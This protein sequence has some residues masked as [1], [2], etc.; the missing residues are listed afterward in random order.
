MARVPELKQF[1]KK[2]GIKIGTIVDLIEYRLSREILVEELVHVELP[3]GYRGFRAR[4]FRS[5]MDGLEHLVLQKGEPTSADPLM[6][7]VHVDLSTRDLFSQ[8][9]YGESVLKL[10]LD[11]I[12]KEGCGALLLLRGQAKPGGLVS[13]IKSICGEQIP[14]EMDAR[15]YGIGAQILRA[16]GVHKIRLLTNKIEKRVGLKAYDLEIVEVVALREEEHGQS[17]ENSAEIKGERQ[18]EQQVDKQVSEAK[19]NQENQSRSGH[20]SIQ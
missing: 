7:R 5:K 10:A 18:V 6:V 11:R 13:E 15:D 19:G 4:V 12:E 1:A 3:M 16:L 9:F 17:E 20:V 2:H 14:P 8:M